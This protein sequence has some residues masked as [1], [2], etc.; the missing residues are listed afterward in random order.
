MQIDWVSNGVIL[1]RYLKD[2]MWRKKKT[3]ELEERKQTQAL[4]CE[5][6]D[7]VKQDNINKKV[8]WQYE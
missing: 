4:Y 6:M 5:L 1:C 8:S 7:C 2:C 3:E